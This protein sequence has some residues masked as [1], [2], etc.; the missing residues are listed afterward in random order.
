MLKRIIKHCLVFVFATFLTLY[1]YIQVKS[2]FVEKTETEYAT[3]VTIDDVVELKCYI[4]RDETLVT[5]DVTGTYN[6]VVSEGEKL[7]KG[8]IIANV[9]STDSEYKLQE[10]IQ[11]INEKIEVLEDSGIANNHFA[12]NINKIDEEISSMLTKTKLDVRDGDY[13]FATQNKNDLLTLFNK[14]YLTVNSLTSFDDLIDNYTNEKNLLTDNESKKTSIYSP[15]SGYFFSDVD[16][17]ESILNI[18]II[19]N[20]TAADF[21]QLIEQSPIKDPVTVGKIISTFEWCT[22]CVVDDEIALKLNTGTYYNI[23]Y[24]YSVGTSISAMLVKKLS[25]PTNSTTVLIFESDKNLFN[26]NFMREQIAEVTLDS[27]NGLKIKKEALRI[28]NGDEGVYILEGNTVLFKRARK[29]HENDGYYVVAIKDSAP[30]NP[31]PYLEMY[32]A[33][34]VNGKDLYDGKV[35][36]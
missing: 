26:F 18:D 15:I 21:L 33:V 22:V 17:Y 4:L 36:E 25:D 28:V 11:E 2:I 23:S 5:S 32:D 7:S 30:E 10:K 20:L 19:E 9:Y 1:F 35:I 14:R 31:I 12:I 6:Y 13:S 24:P 8:E 29:I 34:I 16:G 3:V 27:Y